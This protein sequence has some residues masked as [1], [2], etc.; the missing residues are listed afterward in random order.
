M[1]DVDFVGLGPF[2]LPVVQSAT[3]KFRADAHTGSISVTL[4]VL[5]PPGGDTADITFQILPDQ[6][7]DWATRLQQAVH[8]ARELAKGRKP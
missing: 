6:A 4:A 3:A 1:R 2:H 8:A 7:A 5:V